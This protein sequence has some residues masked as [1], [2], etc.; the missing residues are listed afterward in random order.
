MTYQ[1]FRFF[2]L[3]HVILKLDV[4][5]HVSLLKNSVCRLHNIL[6]VLLHIL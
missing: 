2:Y 5:Q 4:F 3:S 6:Y 1:I